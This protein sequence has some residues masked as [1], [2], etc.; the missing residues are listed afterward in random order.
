MTKMICRNHFCY[1]LFL[2]SVM[3]PLKAH[4]YP[5]GKICIYSNLD[6]CLL[7]KRKIA[8]SYLKL[9]KITTSQDNLLKPQNLELTPLTKSRP[10]G[11]KFPF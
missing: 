4:L 3:D 7:Q 1:H 8:G 9:K 2:D 6:P 11:W 10:H 5:L